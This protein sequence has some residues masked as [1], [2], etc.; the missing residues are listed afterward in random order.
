MSEQHC[1]S[2]F[3]LDRYSCLD[4]S[5]CKGD[6]VL[7]SMVQFDPEHRPQTVIFSLCGEYF[8]TGTS[9]G[10]IE[11]W[12]SCT[13]DPYEI[14]GKEI[15]LAMKSG[16]VAMDLSDRYLACA[17]KEGELA[18]WDL[19]IHHKILALDSIHRIGITSVGLLKHGILTTGCD[20]MIKILG[21]R[22]GRTI[23]IFRGHLSSVT[24]AICDIEESR[25]ISGSID[26]IIK[27]WCIRST[28]CLATIITSAGSC[29][30]L[31]CH[32]ITLLTWIDTDIILVGCRN[33]FIPIIS[34][35]SQ[36]IDTIKTDVINHFN[37]GCLS[38]NK[39][40]YTIDENS[41]YCFQVSNKRLICRKKVSDHEIL[42]IVCNQMTNTI[43]IYDTSGLLQ[44]F[45][46][47]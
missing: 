40:Y 35:T 5:Q 38:N 20:G 46:L 22:S 47:I 19:S 21:I 42:G 45:T 1:F 34:I 4:E 31:V 26:G 18:I 9:D 39:Y 15:I 44:F 29:E 28:E 24:T 25:L 27:I 8:V 7:E 3:G 11:F 6:I 13:G 2:E 10:F 14:S 41:V 33:N 37:Q 36:T 23:K 16:I 30:S 17:S 32:P 43:C 12:K